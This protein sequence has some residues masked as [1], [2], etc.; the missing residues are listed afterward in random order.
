MHNDTVVAY[1]KSKEAS[2]YFPH[3]VPMPSILFEE[4]ALRVWEAHLRGEDNQGICDSMIQAELPPSGTQWKKLL[5]PGLANDSKFHRLMQKVLVWDGLNTSFH[6]MLAVS[7]P[8]DDFEERKGKLV[9]MVKKLVGVNLLHDQALERTYDSLMT[10]YELELL[11]AIVPDEWTLM[12]AGVSAEAGLSD[13]RLTLV[14]VG[15][16]DTSNA[17]WDQIFVFRED[18]EAQYKL[19]RLRRFFSKNY[20]G[21]SRTFIEDD[22]QTRLEE[23]ESVARKFGF[24]TK[25]MMLEAVVSSKWLQGSLAGAGLA[26]LCGH[27]AAALMSGFTGLLFEAGNTAVKIARQKFQFKE[28]IAQHPLGYIIAANESLGVRKTG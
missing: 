13:Y 19:N 7:A 24:E 4:M 2:L 5:P 8:A 27:N 22:L 21:K 18:K 26:A 6:T 15:L 1:T 9:E 28:T 23:H 16:I 3:V 17:S 12:D 10:R 14:D 25:T 20:D 11:P